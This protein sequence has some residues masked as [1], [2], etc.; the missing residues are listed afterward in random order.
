MILAALASERVM[1][2]MGVGRGGIGHF[3]WKLLLDLFGLGIG[4][5]LTYSANVEYQRK[6]PRFVRIT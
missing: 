3:S 5:R 2:F 6:A 4:Q 1:R